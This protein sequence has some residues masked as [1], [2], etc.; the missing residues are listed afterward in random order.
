MDGI[1]DFGLNMISDVNGVSNY[2]LF[3]VCNDMDVMN[4]KKIAVVYLEFGRNRFNSLFRKLMCE[5]QW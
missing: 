3:H 4:E 5:K 1:T 2:A